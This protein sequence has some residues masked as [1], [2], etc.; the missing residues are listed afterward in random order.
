MTDTSEM[1]HLTARA[2]ALLKENQQ[3]IYRRTDR[4]FALLMPLQWAAAVAGAL[5]LSPRT[6]TG[7]SSSVHPHVWLA[8]LFGGL[9][10][11]LPVALAWL[12]P[13]RTLTRYTI[14]CAQVL[15]SSLL[16]HI[17]G[18]R[19]ETHF[20]V[21]GSLAFLATYRDWKLL[22]PPTLLVAADHFLRGAFWPQTVF[23]V[24][25]TSPWRW[26]EHG[27]W[28]IFEDLFLIISIQQTVQ[29]MRASAFQTAE[30]EWN[31][32]QLGRAK[33]QAEA[34]NAA[35]SEFLANMSHEI[36]TPLTG[37][38]GFADVL[39]RGVGSR[40]QRANYL[41]TIQSS[42]QHLLTLINDILDLSKV[43]A[44]RMECERVRCSPHEILSEVLSVLRVRAQEKGLRLDCEWTTPIPDSIET[45][46]ARLRQLLMNLANNAIKFTEAGRVVIRASVYPNRPEP[47]FL[48]EIEDTGI[49]IH[50]EHLERIFLPFDQADNSITRKYGGTGLGLAISRNI[51]KELGGTITV[52]SVLGRGSRF[53]ITLESGSL[54]DVPLSAKYDC[55][56]LRP[57]LPRLPTELTP[58]TLP[59]IRVLLVDDGETNR[60]LV[61]LVLREAGATVVCAENGQV[62]LERAR[63]DAFD[64]ILMDMQM[65]VMDG[66]TATRTLRSLGFRIPILALTAH[67]M[68]GDQEKCL[69]AGCS[70][71]LSKPVQIDQMIETIRA[72]MVDFRHA[73]GPAQAPW[74]MS[75]Q[76]PP[77]IS[78]PSP[79]ISTLPVGLPKF[80]RIVDDFI[81]KLTQQL[82]KMHALCE[83]DDWDELTRLA[84]WLKGAGGTVGFPCLTAPAGNLEQAARQHDGIAA[85][86]VLNELS[87]LT[88]RIAPAPAGAGSI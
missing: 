63:E 4:M 86:R 39:R 69:A 3:Q 1:I 84:H 58:N 31:H 36:R 48:C 12:K 49:G 5:W 56:A 8:L 51:V 57:G 66:Y 88:D 19:I 77:I 29:D 61:S 32:D 47:R 53:R 75:S 82:E 67:A 23:G 25:T 20:H 35:K 74:A 11:S 13:G 27:A 33:E 21:F 44:G 10:C 14:A 83:A 71:Y 87:S 18:G 79:I 26:L 2:D 64:L 68:R 40:E 30:L 16:I 70:G 45:D 9:L 62:G 43:E 7:A 15:F 85:H 80:Q 76:A 37:I 34:A 42:G 81:A 55:D 38:L 73:T 72:A 6:W 50:P 54:D 65:P 17:S 28:V 22:L 60:D 46:P 78:T 24:L 52:E 41:E 59:P